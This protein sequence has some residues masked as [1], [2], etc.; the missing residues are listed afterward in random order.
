MFRDSEGRSFYPIIIEG[1]TN[2]F[3]LDANGNVFACGKN[4]Q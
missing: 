4:P 3:T 1:I 2:E